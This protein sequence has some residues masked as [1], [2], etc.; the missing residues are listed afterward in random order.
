MWFTQIPQ[1]LHS[2]YLSQFRHIKVHSKINLLLKIKIYMVCCVDGY[3][4]K[5]HVKGT[6]KGP[7]TKYSI[8]K[9]LHPQS[10][11]YTS[12]LNLAKFIIF[13]FFYSFVYCKFLCKFARHAVTNTHKLDQFINR[14]WTSRPRDDSPVGCEGEYVHHWL[15]VA[16]GSLW[17]LPGLCSVILSSHGTILGYLYSSFPFI[18]IPL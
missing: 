2:A 7:F 12:P 11:P 10:A 6:G 18:R 15:L 13:C 9:V 3:R 1:L 5:Q 8:H 16:T 14:S 4:H 17:S